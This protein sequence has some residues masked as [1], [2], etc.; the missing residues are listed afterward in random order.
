MDTI[1]D[2]KKREVDQRS[3]TQLLIECNCGCEHFIK[4]EY[5]LDKDFKD[6]WIS[7]VD[8]PRNWKYRIEKALSFIFK[9]EDLY[10]TAAGITSEDMEKIKEHFRKYQAEE[11]HE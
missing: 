1:K 6:Y 4:F 11:T 7:F 8:R 5:S 10:H 9:G 2:K 3:N